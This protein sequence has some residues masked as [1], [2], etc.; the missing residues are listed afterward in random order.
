MTNNNGPRVVL[1]NVCGGL[2]AHRQMKRVSSTVFDRRQRE[3]RPDLSKNM[4]EQ[5]QP[6]HGSQFANTCKHVLELEGF[7]KKFV[8]TGVRACFA[9]F[10]AAVRAHDQDSRLRQMTFDVFQQ[11]EA[12]FRRILV[13][14][15]LQIQDGY[16]GLIECCTSNRGLH[17][18][19]GHDVVLVTQRPIKL[20]RDLRIVIDD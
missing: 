7:G 8:S 1:G 3:W 16:I 5:L 18:V 12:T 20:L 15:H 14:G 2:R 11:P 6:M 13:R 19:R 10:A 4:G 9:D 17:V